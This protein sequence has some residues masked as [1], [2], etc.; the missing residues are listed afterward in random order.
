[1]NE[2]VVMAEH[3]VDTGNRDQSDLLGLSTWLAD[4]IVGPLTKGDGYTPIGA[5]R[6][7]TATRFPEA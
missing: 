5:L 1:M 7:L 3:A 2:F 6:R 4:R